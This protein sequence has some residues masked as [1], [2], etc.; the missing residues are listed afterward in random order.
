[1]KELIDEDSIKEI[2]LVANTPNFLYKRMRENKNIQLIANQYS[3]IELLDIFNDA[4]KK[5]EEGSNL[6][7]LYAVVFSLSYKPHSEVNE[8]FNKLHEIKIRWSDKIKDIYLTS[9]K[10]ISLTRNPPNYVIKFGYTAG[11]SGS[12]THT[13]I[14]KNIKN[15]VEL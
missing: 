5:I 10:A 13:T 8:F 12:E 4:Y 6:L 3:T 11:A 1:M 7:I 2:L 9:R 14:M 15:D